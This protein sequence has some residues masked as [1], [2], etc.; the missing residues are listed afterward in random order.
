VQEMLK[1]EE[2]QEIARNYVFEKERGITD[3]LKIEKNELFPDEMLVSYLS[4]DIDPKD[5]EPG[6]WGT[7]PTW[8]VNGRACGHVVD[9]AQ[10]D[11][12]MAWKTFK[13]WIQADDGSII[14]YRPDD[15]AFRSTT[16]GPKGP[17]FLVP[18]EDIISPSRVLKKSA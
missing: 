12:E 8:S 16:P 9:K 11:W 10:N 14:N 18:P 5:M 15:W 1:P 4:V 6:T 3:S 7:L 2:A 13:L 17:V